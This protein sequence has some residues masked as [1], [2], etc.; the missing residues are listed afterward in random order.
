MSLPSLTL[1]PF[2]GATVHVSLLHGGHTTVPTAYV[3]QDQIPGHDSLDI[4]CFSFLIENK[5]LGKKILYDLG[6]MKAWKEKQPPA[7]ESLSMLILFNTSAHDLNLRSRAWAPRLI[8]VHNHNPFTITHNFSV[9][10]Q[11]KFAKVVMDIPKDVAEQLS[12]ASLPLSSINAIIWS[13]YH[14]DHTGDPSHFPKS[15][16]LVVGPGFKDNK[17]T[18]PGYPKNPDAVVCQDAFEGRD[19]VEIDF[20]DGFE[21]GG[22]KAVDFFGDGSFYL[23]QAS[24]HSK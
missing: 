24:G 7:S 1:P 17:Q 14:T 10:E 20:G 21:I 11:I 22:F 9:I 6:I 13:H 19:L 4:P 15:T 2:Q 18:F 23:L 16:S 8:A 3:F 5:I 12:D